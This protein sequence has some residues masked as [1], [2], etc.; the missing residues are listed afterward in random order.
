MESRE[1]HIRV[2]RTAR[3]RVLGDPEAADEV[4]WVLHGYRQLAERFIRRFAG[5]PGLAAGGRAVVAPEGLSRFYVER[6]V[7]PHGPSSRVGA[8]WMT[9]ADRAHEIEDYV[10]YLDRLAASLVGDETGAAGPLTG[11]GRRQVV[12]GF[13]QGAETASRWAVYGGIRASELILWGGGLAEDLDLGRAAGS[14]ADTVVRFVV[15][16]EDRWARE[17]ASRGEE[18]LRGLGVAGMDVGRVEYDGG[19]VV[20][21][22]VLSR[23]W[24][25]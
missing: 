10:S 25:D 6:E 13:S 8:A 14:L 24:P 23:H 7:G 9:R 5:L 17:R 4:W 16:S 22:E 15:G 18:V 12:L 19:H 11:G 21:P 3:Y 1:G 20:D 2:P